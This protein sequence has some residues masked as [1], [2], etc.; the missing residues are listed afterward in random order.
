MSSDRSIVPL[1]GSSPESMSGMGRS[2]AG[3]V[4]D[5]P[6]VLSRQCASIE[7]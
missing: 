3:T 1:V 4:G 6:E 5:R 2:P 7:S